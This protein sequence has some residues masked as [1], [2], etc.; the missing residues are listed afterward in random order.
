MCDPKSKV[1]SRIAIV[2][3]SLFAFAGLWGRWKNPT[4]GD[5]VRSFSIVT[6]RPNALC[7]P[8]HNRTPAIL[9]PADYPR[10]LGEDPAGPDGLHG[11]LRRYPTDRMRAYA[12]GP[13]VGNVKNDDREL[14][15]PSPQ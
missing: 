14:T 1:L 9:D 8:I 3:G 5:T 15:K 12:I 6:N 13:R 7:A 10:W 4:S 2:D 11:L